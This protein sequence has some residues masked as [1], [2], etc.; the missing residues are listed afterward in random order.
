MTLSKIFYLDIVNV[1][2]YARVL[3][4]FNTKQIL[5]VYPT[6]GTPQDDGWL[7]SALA[8]QY[9]DIPNYAAFYKA[10]NLA[11]RFAY[12]NIGGG[13]GLGQIGGTDIYGAPREFRVG[14]KIE[15]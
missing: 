7:T 5:N 11:N 15:L 2:L 10:V 8:S 12:M 3:N 14:L 6:T 13:G 1:E 9:L 4:L